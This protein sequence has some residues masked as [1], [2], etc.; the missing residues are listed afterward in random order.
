[1]R[2]VYD[3]ALLR[4]F[5]AVAQTLSFTQAA[6]RLG[7]R[8]S[9]VSQHVRRLEEQVGRALFLRD[10]HTVELT[11][12]GAATACYLEYTPADTEPTAAGD[13]TTVTFAAS[14][15]FDFY[16]MDYNDDYMAIAAADSSKPTVYY[17]A[18]GTGGLAGDWSTVQLSLGSA[19]L[20]DIA[21]TGSRWVGITAAGNVYLSD[22]ILTWTSLGN[23]TA[24][25][26]PTH[27]TCDKDTGFLYAYSDSTGAIFVSRDE[28]VAWSEAVA[29]GSSNM[30]AHGQKLG[31]DKKRR[32][33][34]GGDD[35]AA[36]ETFLR[37]L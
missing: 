10:T 5:L 24:G 15:T 16:G 21:W 34:F 22:D 37:T 2:G 25:A 6:R 32:Y 14:S 3:P 18:T 7:V 30:T 20:V 31:Y 23:G 26:G 28:G 27:L 36:I 8:Q 9:T 19:T 12:D 1:M 35:S 4:T 17:A 13:W 29:A 11:G 33:L